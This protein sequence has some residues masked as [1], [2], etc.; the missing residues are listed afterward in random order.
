MR[1]RN[2]NKPTAKVIHEFL[3]I[4]QHEKQ[5]KLNELTQILKDNISDTSPVMIFCN[6][7]KS[8]RAV[9]YH[10]N[11]NGFN[12]TS[13]HSGIPPK[14]CYYLTF[15][16]SIDSKNIINTQFITEKKIRMGKFP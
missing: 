12:A 11:E 9:D 5:D 4:K 6:S 1:G 7:S 16:F 13:L 8:C 10:L 14:V 15:T 2:T 3:R